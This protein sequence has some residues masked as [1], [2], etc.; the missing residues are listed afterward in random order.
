M[1]YI[2]GEGY[3]VKSD[4]VWSIYGVALSGVVKPRYRPLERDRHGLNSFLASCFTRSKDHSIFTNVG[5]V[6]D[7]IKD[8]MEKFYPVSTNFS[9]GF[10]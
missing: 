8:A 9:Y 2:K 4:D 1:S 3:Y 5:K 7:W 6:V 10:L